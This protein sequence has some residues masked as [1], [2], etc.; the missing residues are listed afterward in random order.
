MAG[1]EMRLAC[2]AT[3]DNQ[4]EVKYEWLVDGKSLPEDRIS[5]GHYKI[6]DDHSLVI[7][8]PTQDDT[9]KYKCVVSTKLDQVEKEIKIQFKGTHFSVFFIFKEKKIIEKSETNV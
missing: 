2:D 3:A 8:N 6:D 5:S 9:A 4:L 1:E 7:S